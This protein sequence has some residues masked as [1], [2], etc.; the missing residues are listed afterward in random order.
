[1]GGL[2]SGLGLNSGVLNQRRPASGAAVLARRVFAQ[3]GRRRLLGHLSVPALPPANAC[4]STGKDAPPTVGKRVHPH[5]AA[6]KSGDSFQSLE[7]T[8]TLPH[9]A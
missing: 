9:T 3:A 7:N 8:H 2:P 4:Q 1:M 6:E 5:F